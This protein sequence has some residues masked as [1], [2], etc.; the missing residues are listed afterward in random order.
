MPAGQQRAQPAPLEV[1]A[2]RDRGLGGGRVVRQPHEAGDGAMSSVVAGRKADDRVVVVA[3]DLGQVAQL[4]RR[5]R[6]LGAEEALLDALVGEVRH[7]FDELLLVVGA[8][9]AEVDDAC[10]RRAGRT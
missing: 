8:D 5:E 3:V 6:R 4:G 2:D 10:C 7:A 9:L 1:V